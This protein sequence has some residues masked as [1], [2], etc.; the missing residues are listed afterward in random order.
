MNNFNTFEQFN[1]FKL[2]ELEKNSS[3]LIV[4]ENE[5]TNNITYDFLTHF[6][7][8]NQLNII[9]DNCE[10]YEY[11]KLFPEAKIH[12][13]YSDEIL[14]KLLEQQSTNESKNVFLLIHSNDLI[15]D[16]NVILCEISYNSRH[17]KILYVLKKEITNKLPVSIRINFDYFFLSFTDDV[18]LIKQFYNDYAG[19]FKTFDEFKNTF[20]ELTK[21]NKIMVISNN[22]NR[23]IFW[24]KPTMV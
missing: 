24:Y 18:K 16:K 15:F 8:T 9:D 4:N 3:I 7:N 2:N 6:K 23:K 17:Y 1:E 12:Q 20:E 11:A 19:M 21:D 22:K 14:N 5:N 10:K 13:K